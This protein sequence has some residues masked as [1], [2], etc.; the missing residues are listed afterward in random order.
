V[1]CEKPFVNSLKEAD[2]IIALSK[3]AGRQVVVNNQFRFMRVH[4]AAKEKTGRPEF[5]DLLFVSM[6][7]TF[8]VTVQTEAGWRGQDS[9]CMERMRSI[10]AAISSMR[11]RPRS[12]RA[13]PEVDSRKDRTTST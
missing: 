1:F 5:G 3:D 8:L 10:F 13:C 2:A 4:R 9:Q 6:H 11:I 12:A 7:Q